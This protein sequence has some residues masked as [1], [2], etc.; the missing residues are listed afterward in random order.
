MEFENPFFLKNRV[1]YFLNYRIDLVFGI[2]RILV[3]FGLVDD[4]EVGGFLRD[5]QNSWIIRILHFNESLA[6]IGFERLYA[7]AIPL[8]P[9]CRSAWK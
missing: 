6:D 8:A 9:Y 4:F 2:S 7:A 5:H 1:V 3:D